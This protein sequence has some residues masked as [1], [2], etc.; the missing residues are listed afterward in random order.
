M[1]NPSEARDA[2]GMEMFER[3]HSSLIRAAEGGNLTAAK[4]E[5]FGMRYRPVLVRYAKQT[6]KIPHESAEDAVQNLLVRMW[7]SPHL[8]R[9]PPNGKFRYVLAAVLRNTVG[10]A[11][12]KERRYRG[13]LSRLDHPWTLT[14]YGEIR[15]TAE[16][17]FIAYAGQAFHELIASGQWPTDKVDHATLEQWHAHLFEGATQEEIAAEYGIN[18]ATVSRHI[19]EVEKLLLKDGERILGALG[20]A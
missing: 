16:Q 18:Q 7:L 9:R 10:N 4:W 13:L 6:L 17:A 8:I 5:A 1:R 11:L 14:N 19:K 2:R 12:K 20:L 15:R 3:T